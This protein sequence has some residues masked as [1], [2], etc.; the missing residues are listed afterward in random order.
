[1]K[2]VL[3][4]GFEAFG[5]ADINPSALAAEKLD[6]RT[7]ANHQVVAA[8]LPCAFEA[9]LVEL[10]RQLRRVQPELVICVGQAGG[11]KAITVERVALN[12]DDAPIAD[13]L[14]AQPIDQPI[15]KRGPVGYWSTLPIKS[16]ALALNE[17]GIEA[18]VSETAGTFVCNHV[19][20][21]LMHSLKRRPNVRGGFVHVPFIPRQAKVHKK[22][23]EP[24][25]PLSRIVRGLELAIRVAIL[26]PEESGKTGGATH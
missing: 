18:A 9:S 17:A 15:A 5:G 20:Y 24:S 10:K 19:F 11:R 7:I 26:T 21:G 16:I 4:T 25:M 14:G 1:M 6:G 13:N 3:L 8:I 22:H 23:R 2:K 12:V